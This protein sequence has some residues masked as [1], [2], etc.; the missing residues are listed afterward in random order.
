M[1]IV[2]GR[3]GDECVNE[4]YHT[5]QH[6]Q[7]YQQH[8]HDHPTNLFINGLSPLATFLGEDDTVCLRELLDGVFVGGDV[9][10]WHTRYPPDPLLQSFITSGNNVTSV[11]SHL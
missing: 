9:H 1:F 8:C 7:M 6:A 3:D 2:E 5:S 4:C 10:D 11:L